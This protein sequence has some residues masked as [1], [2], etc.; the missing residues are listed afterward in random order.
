MTDG[1][2]RAASGDPA[3]ESG[4][5]RPGDEG[6]GE[7]R[8]GTPW[9]GI[10]AN[11]GSG[12]GRSRRLVEELVHELR[13]LGVPAEVAWTPAARAALVQ[14]AAREGDCRCLVAVGGDGTISALLNERPGS[15][16]TVMPAGTENLVARHF[17]L[18]RDPHALARSIAAGRTV[19]VDVA[20]AA[21]RR[22]LLMA[23][24]GFDADVVARHHRSRISHTGH[25]QPTSRMAYVLPVL[26]ASF[27]YRFPTISVRI[28]DP[29]AEEMLRGS[30]VFIFNLPRY[31]LGLPFVPVAREDDGWLD[32]VIFRH[33]GPFRAFYYLCKV[34][35]RIHLQDPSVYHRRVRKVVVT[36]REAIPVQLDGDPGGYVLPGTSAPAGH[37]SDDRDHPAPAERASA[38]SPTARLAEW[39]VE[40]LPS[41]MSM[42]V[43]PRRPSRKEGPGAGEEGPG[44]RG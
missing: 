24:F 8:A 41:G 19:P 34:F 7:P 38:S 36:A 42:L 40:I 29:G 26:R 9:V 12:V 30:T 13:R 33:P 3:Q 25:I 21:G 4:R 31:A 11:R 14:R 1:S 16:L 6:S 18:R 5:P 35:C 37:G 23:G 20:E 17:G 22:F 10:V 32:L 43:P 28:L 15:P 27:T 44:A 2:D 39:A